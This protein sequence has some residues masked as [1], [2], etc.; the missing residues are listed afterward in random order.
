M[1]RSMTVG[2]GPAALG[3]LLGLAPVAPGALADGSFLQVDLSSSAADAV[4][5]VTRGRL[6]FGANH[7]DYDGGAVTGLSLTHAFPLGDA[8]TLKLGPA[9]S[10]V[11]DD[12]DGFESPR[13]GV[14]ASLDRYTA[15]AFGSLYL[16]GEVNTIDSGWFALVQTGLGSGGFSV[17]LSRGGSDTYDEATLAV[18]QRL[19]AG[20][21]N[22]R[23]G[24]RFIAEEAF[25]GVSV[26]TF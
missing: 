12:D 23:A 25:V 8:A 24:W 3:L 10:V 6:S 4:G 15:T 2:I 11:R 17:E 9:L 14:K 5:T 16:L 18:N 20:P 13:A 21:M 19:G 7:N 26:N 1:L 22:L